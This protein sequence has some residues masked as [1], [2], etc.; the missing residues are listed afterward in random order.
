MS[1]EIITALTVNAGSGNT[2]AGAT[3]SAMTAN[4]S[5]SF[6]YSASADKWIREY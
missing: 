4:V 1:S 6:I 3:L 2:M 5:Y